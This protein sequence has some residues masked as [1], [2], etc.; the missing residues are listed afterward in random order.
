MATFHAQYPP[1]RRLDL[2]EDLFGHRVADPYRWLE[3]ADSAETRQWLAAEEE[4]WTAY[5]ADLP[6]RDA[7]AARVRELLQVGYV[8]VPAWRGT[9]CFYTRRD[10]GQEHGVLYVADGAGERVLVD[11]GVDP[12]GRTTLDHWQ[13]DKE[14]RLLAYQLSSGGN[15]ESLLRVLDV[16]SGEDI[17]GPIDRCRYSGIAWLPGGKAFYYV[18]RLPPEAVPAGEQ[19]YHRRV[20]LHVVGT[21]PESDAM[22]FGEGR[23]KTSYYGVSVSR[24]GRWLVI[25]ASIGTAPREDVWLAD[26]TTADPASPVL[27]PVTV[28]LD[29]QTSLRA[30]RDGRLYVYTDLDAPRGRICVADPAAPGPEGWR[31]LIP[32]DP[33]AVL[34]GYAILDELPRPVLVVSLTRHAIIEVAVHDLTTGEPLSSLELPGLGS[35][36]GIAERP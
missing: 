31:D 3:D 9:S 34:R 35:V 21:A 36:G 32:E 27:V 33:S 2:V 12:S 17:D 14:G 24:D 29:A 30:G 20:Y 8:G 23:D 10:P 28:G 25:S 22:V 5:R 11:P 1:A 6:R 13:P 18:R 16:T 19:Q 15:E 26:L 4:L 7:F